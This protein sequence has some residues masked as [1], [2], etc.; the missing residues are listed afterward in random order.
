MISIRLKVVGRW[1]L[2]KSVGEFLVLANMVVM[3]WIKLIPAG[4][5]E[6]PKIRE[7]GRPIIFVGW[8]GHNFI[9]LGVYLK[10]FSQDSRAVI[11]VRDDC[12]GRTL[13]RFAR[14]RNIRVVFL[15]K[16]PSS[17][18]GAIGIV[19]IIDLLKDGYDVLIAVDGPEGPAYQVRPGAALM[20]KR[21]DAVLVPILATSN[22]QM[23]LV[24]HWDRPMIPLPLARTVVRFGPVIDPLERHSPPPTV[25]ELREKIAEALFIG[26][27]RAEEG[28]YA[29]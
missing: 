29:K 17:F 15:G 21:S 20:A 18:R 28:Q 12:G 7:Q 27:H 26:M 16:D 11:M 8:H 14:R 4:Y 2:E 19:K 10:M 22:R 5:D 25:D 24:T 23:N 1:L 9:N 6:I 13:A 3:R